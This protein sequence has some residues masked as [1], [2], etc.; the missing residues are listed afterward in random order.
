MNIRKRLDTE[1]YDNTEASFA[2]FLSILVDEIEELQQHLQEKENDQHLY[3]ATTA[4][5]LSCFL[6]NTIKRIILYENNNID[7]DKAKTFLNRIMNL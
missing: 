2:D 3:D 7:Y 5:N 1:Y 4:L 6:C